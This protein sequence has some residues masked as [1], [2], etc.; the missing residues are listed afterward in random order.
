MPRFVY[1][2]IAA[3]TT[4]LMVA[5]FAAPVL[6]QT[7]TFFGVNTNGQNVDANAGGYAAGGTLPGFGPSAA[8]S[9]SSGTAWGYTYR[10]FSGGLNAN[11]GFSGSGQSRSM[12]GGFTDYFAGGAGSAG[13]FDLSISGFRF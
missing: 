4:A 10:D 5:A 11:A 1:R 6:A 13:M 2:G 8:Q 7:P 9:F 12:N 3:V